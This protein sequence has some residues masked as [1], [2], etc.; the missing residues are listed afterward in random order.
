MEEVSKVRR[1]Y[2]KEVK[3]ISNYLNEKANV[4]Q[5]AC[6]HITDKW[7]EHNLENIFTL[8]TKAIH[9]NGKFRLT[10]LVESAVGSNNVIFYSRQDSISEQMADHKPELK[11]TIQ[12]FVLSVMGDFIERG[13]ESMR[14]ET[15]EDNRFRLSPSGKHAEDYA[16][17]F[18]M[19]VNDV[20]EFES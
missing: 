19:K 20:G 3:Y 15:I 14:R 16:L 8:T 9:F 4:L 2:S 13:I 12:D 11:M 10:V 5:H 17:A 6:K 7:D 18:P 1:D